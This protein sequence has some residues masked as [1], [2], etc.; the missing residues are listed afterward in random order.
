MLWNAIPCAELGSYI[1][2]EKSC[3]YPQPDFRAGLLTPPHRDKGKL[4][5]N[6]IKSCPEIPVA[7]FLL[8]SLPYCVEFGSQ[9]DEEFRGTRKYTGQK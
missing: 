2:N 4:I 8:H 1:F 3:E 7:P 9:E 5:R 6:V